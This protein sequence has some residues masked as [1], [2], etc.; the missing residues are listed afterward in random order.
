MSDLQLKVIIVSRS[1][2]PG[3]Y[4]HLLASYKMLSENN[5][6]TFMYHHALF[7]NMS[8]IKKERVFNSIFELK[9]LGKIDFAFF[10]FPSLKNIIDITLL[11]LFY[12]TQ[13]IYVL[14][15]PFES[16]RAYFSAGFGPLKTFRILIVS[17]VNY[18]LVILSDKIV[19]P[20]KNSFSTF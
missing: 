16:V 5:I 13:V 4:S 18:L 12:R 11:R 15:E 7:N 14:H 19:L 8:V 9:A 6:N 10:W 17:L 2:N 1:F 3:H 20:S